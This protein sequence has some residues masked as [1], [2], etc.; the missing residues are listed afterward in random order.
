M[1]RKPVR[2]VYS[3]Y[4][5]TNTVN[6][7]RY[8]GLTC[9]VKRRWQ[10]HKDAHKSRS[11]KLYA[12]M[13]KYGVKKFALKI[14]TAN[15]S[16]E[17]ANELEQELIRKLGTA[18]DGY[19]CTIGG[20]G[21]GGYRHSDQT[22]KRISEVLRR[23]FQTFGSW[24]AG[25]KATAEQRK[26]QSERQQGRRHSLETRRKMSISAQKYGPTRSLRQKGW[27]FTEEHKKNISRGRKGKAMPREA[28]EHIAALNRGRKFS[29]SARMN[30]SRGHRRVTEAD[31]AHARRR[32]AE[33]AVHRIIGLELGI[34]QSHVSRILSGTA[35]AINPF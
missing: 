9:D 1:N 23:R 14:I 20:R 13:R 33:G 4:V 8:I 16:K 2:D 6:G 32:R 11:G 5:I 21:M 15:L 35:W 7:K 10:D 34:C 29:V 18:R 30:I 25:R 3:V 19:N 26:R 31:V 17:S 24:N 12:A 22:K 27:Q 28:V